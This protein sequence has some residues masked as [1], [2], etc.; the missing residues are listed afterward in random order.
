M[1]KDQARELSQ[2]YTNPNIAEYCVKQ[3][4][5]EG[6]DH[7][8]EPSAGAGH[9]LDLL[10]EDR[11]VGLDIDP[12]RDDISQMDFFEYT[13]PDGSKAYVGNP[14]FG[15]RSKLAVSFFNKCALDGDLIAFI[16]PTAWEKYEIHNKLDKG[17]YLEHSERLP[18]NSF[19]LLG[20]T[21]NVNCIWQIWKRGV[22][23]TDLR[24]KDKPPTSHVDFEM[25]LYNNTEGARKYFDCE[26]DIAVQRQ[27]FADYERLEVDE[28]DCE[29]NKHWMFFKAKSPEILE[30]I[31]SFDFTGLSYQTM[32]P[33]FGKADF[34]K[35][36]KEV[37]E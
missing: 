1:E 29:R 15:R 25:Y 13:P 8:I 33:G 4:D 6:Y 28:K 35:K 17:F 12:K 34:I 3:L 7:V 14:P 27:G 26:W 37:Y 9:F 19:L 18:K 24:I 2:F 16:I 5:L 23:D 21:Y 31:T 32:I 36:Y 11:K 20:E 22:S 10:P 30:R